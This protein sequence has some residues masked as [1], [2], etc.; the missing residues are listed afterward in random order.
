MFMED[1]EDQT[2]WFPKTPRQRRRRN[3]GPAVGQR[4]G[5]AEKRENCCLIGSPGMGKTHL[6]IALGLAACRAGRRVTSNLAFS[7]WV[8]VLQGERMRPPFWTGSPTTAI[9]SR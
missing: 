3:A 2:V 5:E 8:Q 4:A 1:Y 9:S 6:T 7:E